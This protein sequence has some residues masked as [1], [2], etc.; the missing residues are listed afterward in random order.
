MATKYQVF[1]S[2]TY[3]DLIHERNDAREAVLDLNH[4]PASMEGFPAIGL[5][6]MTY[7]KRVIDDSDYY[8]LILAGRYGSVNSSGISYT[9]LE[10]EYAKQTNKMILCFPHG[11]IS[12]LPAKHTESDPFLLAK[13]NEFRNEVMTGR[14]VRKWQSREELRI[15]LTKSLARA[16]AEFPQVGWV[17]GNVPATEDVLIQLNDIRD[18]NDKLR[19]ASNITPGVSQVKIAQEAVNAAARV[20]LNACIKFACV[21]VGLFSILFA[22]PILVTYLFPSLS[23]SWEEI[24]SDGPNRSLL[25]NLYLAATAITFIAVLFST[26]ASAAGW[27]GLRLMQRPEKSANA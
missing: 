5:E 27:V 19:K 24:A 4:I 10:Y 15:E 18:E 14:I 7:I 8:V 2:A 11:D 6:Q 9:Q 16:F 1:I 13:L 17:R 26:V 23:T 22:M 3:V 25:G 21:S 20:R 12:S